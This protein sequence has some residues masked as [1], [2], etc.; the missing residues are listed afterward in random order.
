MLIDIN[1]L[2]LKNISIML[3]SRKAIVNN[4]NDIKLSLI[5]ITQSI[6]SVQKIILTYKNTIIQLK[7]YTNVLIIKTALS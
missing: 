6:N 4:C 1:I 2:V 7:S 3:L 5:I